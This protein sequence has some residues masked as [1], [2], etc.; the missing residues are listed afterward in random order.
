[1]LR[2]TGALIVAALLSL[3]GLA[4]A[5]SCNVVVDFATRSFTNWYKTKAV[6]KEEE[7]EEEEEEYEEETMKRKRKRKITKETKN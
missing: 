5:Q 6:E 1:M 7:Y 3:T 4:T 2:H